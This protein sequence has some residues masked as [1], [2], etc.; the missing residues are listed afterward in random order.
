L[1]FDYKGLTSTS[2]LPFYKIAGLADD[3]QNILKGM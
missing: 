3:G 2:G 1:Y